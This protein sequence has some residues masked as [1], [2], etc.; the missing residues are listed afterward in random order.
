MEVVCGTDVGRQLE[1]AACG[2][3]AGHGSCPA[4][5]GGLA[6]CFGLL[7]VT[8]RALISRE[9]PGH[10]QHCTPGEPSAAGPCLGHSGEG[11]SCVSALGEPSARFKP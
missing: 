6:R 3:P 9:M 7:L 5:L 2:L 10:G 11:R 4:W 8:G 1:R